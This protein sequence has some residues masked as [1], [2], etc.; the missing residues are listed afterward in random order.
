MTIINKI[1]QSIQARA[2]IGSQA[3]IRDIHQDVQALRYD[4]QGLNQ[5][6]SNIVGKEGKARA[7]AAKEHQKQV[8][9]KQDKAIEHRNQR[10]STGKRLAELI[11]SSALADP[12]RRFAE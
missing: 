10:L 3:E 9:Q 4:L 2:E 11:A 6:F 8:E 12:D 5:G 7:E 1:G